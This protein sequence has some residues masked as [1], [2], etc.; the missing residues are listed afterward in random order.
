[1][2]SNQG[3]AKNNIRLRMKQ[4]HNYTKLYFSS[5]LF[6]IFCKCN[7]VLIYMGS[8]LMYSTYYQYIYIH[9]NCSWYTASYIIIYRESFLIYNSIY[10]TWTVLIY[11]YMYF[12]IQWNLPWET[13][14]MVDKPPLR[15]HVSSNIWPYVS[16]HLYF[17]W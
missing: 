3:K 12:H 11:I 7:F 14:T 15:D 6:Y 5:F 9:K 4:L 13:T 8:L 16:L 1:M 2:D 17:W 10:Y